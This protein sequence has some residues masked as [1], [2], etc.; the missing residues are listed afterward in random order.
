MKKFLVAAAIIATF[1]FLTPN[2]HAGYYCICVGYG[3][4]PGAPCYVNGDP[5]GSMGTFVQIS[6]PSDKN[7]S[8]YLSKDNA[9]KWKNGTVSKIYDSSTGWLCAP[10]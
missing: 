10:Y 7:A 3:N 8:K 6:S 1:C 4:T 9:T 2:V 5:E